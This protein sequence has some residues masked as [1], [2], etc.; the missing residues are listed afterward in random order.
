M[1]V[2]CHAVRRYLSALSRHRSFRPHQSKESYAVAAESL[3]LSGRKV[4]SPNL[5]MVRVLESPTATES[6]CAHV[7]K[8]MEA[9]LREDH[10][11]GANQWK[12]CCS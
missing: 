10:L 1:F 2:L 12:N 3:R 9:F 4:V 6:I 11:E 7:P 8:Q 5:Q